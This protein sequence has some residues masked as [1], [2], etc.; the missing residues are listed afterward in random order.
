[1]VPTKQAKKKEEVTAIVAG[2]RF[3]LVQNLEMISKVE[4]G[5]SMTAVGRF[6]NLNESTVR[7]T[8]KYKDHIKKAVEDSSPRARA[9]VVKVAHDAYIAPT[10]R[11]L[12]VWQEDCYRKRVPCTRPIVQATARRIYAQVLDNANVENR[13][14]PTFN[15]SRGL[16]QNVYQC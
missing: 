15:A 2:K 7:T 13:E 11:A 8:M 4:A 12:D 3:S 16:F 1:M 9:N 5:E 10:E 14:N 6:Y